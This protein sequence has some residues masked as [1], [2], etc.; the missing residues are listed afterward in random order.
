[1]GY[2]RDD[3]DIRKALNWFVDHQLSDG[4]WRTSYVE[5]T[6]EGVDKRT[7]RTRERQLW[8]TLRIAQIFKRFYQ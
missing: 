8:L 4:L 1:M 5:G 3:P 6:P 2:S 7:N